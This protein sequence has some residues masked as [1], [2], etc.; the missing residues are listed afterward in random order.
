MGIWFGASI[1]SLIEIL[2]LFVDIVLI[3]IGQTAGTN[4]IDVGQWVM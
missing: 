4:A 3:L 1:A 2:E